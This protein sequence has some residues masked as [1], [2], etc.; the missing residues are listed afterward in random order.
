[1]REEGEAE[2]EVVKAQRKMGGDIKPEV[3][4]C[5]FLLLV[6]NQPFV[7]SQWA[8][9][10]VPEEEDEEEQTGAGEEEK[11]LGEGAGRGGSARRR[12]QRIKVGRRKSRR[13]G[14]GEVGEEK[15]VAGG[16]T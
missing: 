12:R 3:K 2:L 13:R 10:P 5:L 9:I 11:L 14:R 7:M 16:G 8:L 4:S 15:G 6:H 1:M